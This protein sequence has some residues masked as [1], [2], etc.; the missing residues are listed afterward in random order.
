[1]Q[2]QTLDSGFCNPIN[3]LVM[4]LTPCYSDIM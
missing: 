1:M 4:F 3:S 2:N